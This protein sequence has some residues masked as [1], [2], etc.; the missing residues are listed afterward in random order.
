MKALV[1]GG[2]GA[3]GVLIAQGLAHR[4]YAVTILHRGVHEPPELEP[5]VHIHADPHFAGPVA[6]AIGEA[7]YDVVVVTYGRLGLL[8]PLF[9]HRCARLLAIGGM[10]IYPGYLDP[11]SEA[12]SGMPLLARE[13]GPLADPSTM[14]DP[15][16]ARFAGKMLAAEAAVMK[17]HARGAYAATVFRYPAVYGP[18]GMSL[19]D[20]SIIQR[21]QD[22]RDFILL[23]NAGLGIITRCAA[24]NAAW[25]VLA[26]LDRKEAEGQAFNCADEDQ[27]TLGQWVEM[28]LSVLGA[29]PELVPLPAQLNWAAAHLLPLGGSAAPHGLLDISK[30][31]KLLDYR[32]QVTAR[33]ALAATLAWRLANPPTD[34]ER[35]GWPDPLDYRLEDR[36]REELERAFRNLEPVRTTPDV[37][38]PYPHPKEPSLAPDHRGR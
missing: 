21:V 27:Y 36:V 13:E 7:T 26:S 12:P 14:R 30:A 37:V 29:S 6:E 33:D 38:H 18:R 28:T 19:N 25:C 24:I 9:A 16:A 11:M 32:D 17:Q 35:A 10:P 31:R 20:W 15:G 8:A 3:T 23:P 5:F 1:V 4:G 2:S 34:A 22:R